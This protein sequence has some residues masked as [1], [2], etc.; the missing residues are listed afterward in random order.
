[1][2]LTWF[3]SV[4]SCKGARNNGNISN[5]ATELTLQKHNLMGIFSGKKESKHISENIRGNN[6]MFI[7]Y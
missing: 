1:M 3:G 6:Y 2:L 7:T 4:G 5:P